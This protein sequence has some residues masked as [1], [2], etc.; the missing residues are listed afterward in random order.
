VP[1]AERITYEE[2][3]AD[4]YRVRQIRRIFFFELNHM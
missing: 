3:E 1:D 4:Y 2:L